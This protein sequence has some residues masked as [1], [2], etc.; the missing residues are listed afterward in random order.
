MIPIVQKLTAFQ[1]GAL[2]ERLLALSVEDRLLRFGMLT[3]D[4]TIRRYVE[5][6]DFV[7]DR[8][9]GIFGLDLRLIGAAHLAL[10]HQN[11]FAEI[12]V[13]VNAGE[14]RH[15]YGLALLQRAKLH[16]VN[17]GFRTFFMCCLS[18]NKTMVH[19]AHLAGFKVVVEQGDVDAHLKLE[20]PNIGGVALEAVE[21]Q[22]AVMDLFWKQQLQWFAVPVRA[23]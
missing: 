5:K 12:G 13:S 4:D 17:R 3:N 23:A 20:A 6:I 9:F 1:R 10:N 8:V 21:D 22:I 7:S 15:G 18:E 2:L 11:R 19:L 14:R 16:A